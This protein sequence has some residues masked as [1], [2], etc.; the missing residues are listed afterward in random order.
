MVGVGE[1]EEEAEKN[2]AAIGV[3]DK[4]LVGQINHKHKIEQE[5]RQEHRGLAVLDRMDRHIGSPTRDRLY[6]YRVP[7]SIVRRQD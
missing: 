6:Y 2:T 4:L 3:M 5:S 7:E 1:L